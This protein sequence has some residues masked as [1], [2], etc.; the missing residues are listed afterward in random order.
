LPANAAC[1]AQPS[2]A[3]SAATKMNFGRIA[4]PRAAIDPKS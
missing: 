2:E 3:A 4:F 1:P